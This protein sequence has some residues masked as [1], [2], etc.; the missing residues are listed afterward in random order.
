[1][2]D[3]NAKIEAIRIKHFINLLKNFNR[4]EYQYGLKW[5]KFKMKNYINNINII[6][7]ESCNNK[8][9]E[10]IKKIIDE[11]RSEVNEMMNKNLSMNLKSIYS[12][13]KKKKEISPEIE[14][15]CLLNYMDWKLVY[16]KILHK[17]LQSKLKIFNYKL[18]FKALSVKEKFYKSKKCSICCKEI[19]DLYD[20]LYFQCPK[21]I[22]YC[23]TILKKE[24]II[25]LNK[26]NLLYFKNIDEKE[27]Y[28]FQDLNMTYIIYI[29][30]H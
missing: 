23:D 25:R 1:M 30:K 11:N 6:P 14:K 15:N 9:Y 2:I 28:Y 4:I 12:V 21:L 20:H 29:L 22:A 27:I 19:D 13:L 7:D 26:D 17:K 5:I 8:Y 18:L 16:K 10:N 24:D 3:I